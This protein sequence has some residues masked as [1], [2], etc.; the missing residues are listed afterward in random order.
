MPLAKKSRR[1]ARRFRATA[2]ASLVKPAL[3]GKARPGTTSRRYTARS[4]LAQRTASRISGAEPRG[5]PQAPGGDNWSAPRG[6]GL[7]SRAGPMSSH[8]SGTASPI[9]A[10]RP[11][12][13]PKLAARARPKTKT[14]T[15]TKPQ[16]TPS[17]STTRQPTAHPQAKTRARTTTRSARRSAQRPARHAGT[18]HNRW[19]P[20]PNRTQRLAERSADLRCRECTARCPSRT[21]SGRSARR[22]V[23][24]RPAPRAAEPRLPGAPTRRTRS[25]RA[26]GWAAPS[27]DGGHHSMQ[28]R[29]ARVRGEPC[30]FTWC[31]SSLRSGPWSLRRAARGSS[32]R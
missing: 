32:W 24:T 18:D 8:S 6:S 4:A 22:A 5:E 16:P 21:S 15:K 30:A 29:E 7:A 23:F 20:R 11:S 26:W 10:R 9:Q 27:G 31:G 2:S 1:R 14:K 28:R 12:S 13:P 19:A 25:G 17:P 3:N